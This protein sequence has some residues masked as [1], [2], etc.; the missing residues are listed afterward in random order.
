MLVKV[1]PSHTHVSVLIVPFSQKG[2][3]KKNLSF[4]RVFG[5]ELFSTIEWSKNKQKKKK[6]K[7]RMLRVFFWF[8][9]ETDLRVAQAEFD[10]QAEI[11]K[12]LLEG[13]TSTHVSH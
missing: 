13:V 2:P 4:F 11:T 8:Q 3:K 10:R 9:A 6:N 1:A 12:L 5:I 7:T